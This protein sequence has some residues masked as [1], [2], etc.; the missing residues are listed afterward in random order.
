MSGGSPALWSPAF[1]NLFVARVVS[2]FGDGLVLVA[3][4]A[5]SVAGGLASLARPAR[6]PLAVGYTLSLGYCVLLVAIALELPL[7]LIAVAAA[8]AGAG[9]A[10][11]EILYEAA[12]QEHVPG[13]VIARVSAWDWLGSTMTRPIGFAAVGP[14]AAATGAS[15]TLAVAAGVTAAATC[16]ALLVPDVRN[17]THAER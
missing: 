15:T 7:A 14:I 6:R 9:L 12:V 3:L 16:A 10:Y 13:R 8:L 4:A 11:S 1:R 5:G 17:L 2:V